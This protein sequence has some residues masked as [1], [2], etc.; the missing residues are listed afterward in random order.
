MLHPEGVTHLQG[1]CFMQIF[2]TF[3]RHLPHF[4]TIT[5]INEK[6]TVYSNSCDHA[7][8]GLMPGQQGIIIN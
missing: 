2:G 8:A 6:T 5:N 3:T 7:A 1:F 4:L